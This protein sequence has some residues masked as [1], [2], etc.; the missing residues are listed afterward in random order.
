MTGFGFLMSISATAVLTLLAEPLQLGAQNQANQNHHRYHHYQLIDIGTFGGPNS[1][2][3]LPSPEVRLLSNSGVAV[4]SA[5]TPT[6]DPLCINFNFD[7]YVSEGFKWRDGVASNL[8]A[9]PGSNSSIAGWVNDTGL[10]TG[11]SQKGIDPLTGGPAFEA[12]LWGEDGELTDLG[13]FGGNQSSANAVNNRGQ[14]A[15]EALNPIPDPFTG[16]FLI[17]GATQVHAFRWTKSQGM[18]DLGT[19]GGTDSAALFINDRGQI[20]GWSFTNTTVNSSTGAPTMDPFLWEDGRMM[21][22]GTLGGTFG[23]SFSLNNRGQVVGFSHMA[24]DQSCHPFLWD[25]KGGMRDLGTL[26]GDSGQ[27]FFVNDKGEVVGVANL[28]GALGCDQFNTPEHAFLWKNGV[29]TDLGSP[30]GD[31]CSFASAINSKHQIVGFGSDC[32]SNFSSTTFHAFLSEDGEPIADLNTLIP[33]NPN[34]QLNWA[35]YINDAGEIAAVGSFSNGDI[36]A[37]VL[38]PCDDDHPDVQGCDYDLIDAETAALQNPAPHYLPSATR[39]LPQSRRSNR[40]HFQAVGGGAATLTSPVSPE[41]DFTR[42]PVFWVLATPL[43]PS[44]VHP[45]ESSTSSVTAGVGTNGGGAGTVVTLTCSVQPT[46]PL[47]PTC[48]ISPASYTFGGTPSTLT[49][50]TVGP[51]GRLLS[52]PGSGLLYALWLP[53]IGLVGVGLGVGSSSNGRKR[54]L[55]TALPACAL[56]VGLASQL[57]CGGGKSSPGTPAGM[58]EVTVTA[59]GFIPVASTASLTPLQVQ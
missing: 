57:A 17:P 13:T 58:Y 1:S 31:P 32:Q 46:P 29:M 25:K 42:P 5:D 19:L 28:P 4:G 33:P 21:D 14:V 43:T 6:L 12:V 54:K 53:L 9:L 49:V 56:F 8:G 55:K 2:F 59:T 11:I 26:G 30:D 40:F 16:V 35:A 22:L 52:H 3:V 34:L 47:A 45:G 24:G 44:P 39:P 7:C 10:V 37:F 38:I 20:N 23:K 50:S 48:S 51:S 36:R 15:G 18:L 41:P 27:A